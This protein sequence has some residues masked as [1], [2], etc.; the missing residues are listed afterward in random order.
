[1]FKIKHRTEEEIAKAGLLE[2]GNYAFCVKNA[3]E[4]VSDKGNNMIELQLQIFDTH[5]KERIIK[6]WLVD[7]DTMHYKIKHFC[8]STGQLDVYMADM[9]S[10]NACRGKNGHLTLDI[11]KDNKNGVMV[12]RVHDYI[13]AHTMTYNDTLNDAVP[14]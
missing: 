1:M 11:K 6:D 13:K 7:T 4:K 9:L 8:E 2:K 10:A 3:I 12:N 14:F 5:N